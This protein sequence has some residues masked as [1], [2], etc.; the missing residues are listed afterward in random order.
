V[1]LTLSCKELLDAAA[2]D[3]TRAELSARMGR[4]YR[5]LTDLQQAL[6]FRLPAYLL[7]T[8]A[9]KLTGFTA[10]CESLSPRARQEMVGWSNPATIDAAYRGE[11]VTEAFDAL[12]RRLD[13]LQMEVFAEGPKH[14]GDLLQ[15]PRSIRSPRTPR[16][17]TRRSPRSSSS[18]RRAAPPRPSSH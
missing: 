1:I 9:E 6:G 12:G 5:R 11:W 17:A 16:A 8:G 2:N 15:L 7:L 13:D 18:A 14:G 4:I 3:V 10:L